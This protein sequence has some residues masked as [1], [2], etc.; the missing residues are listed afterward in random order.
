M[1]NAKLSNFSSLIIQSVISLLFLFAIFIIDFKL[2]K[3]LNQ[4]NENRIYSLM[5]MHELRQSSDDLTRMV[6]TY[7]VTKNTIYKQH[8]L[9]ILEIRNGTRKRP[10]DY[11][12]I[13]W[14]LVQTDNFRPKPFS[15]QSVALLE[16]MRDAK[17]THEEFVK[18]NEAKKKSDDLTQIELQAMRILESKQGDSRLN[19]QIALN[20]VH[21]NLYHEKKASI[22]K[23]IDECY[24]LIN[25]R[26]IKAVEDANTMALM[27]KILLNGIGL[28]IFYTFYRLYK[29][30]KATLGGSLDDVHEHI[31]KIGRGE[32]TPILIDQK[33]KNSILGWLS[34]TQERLQSLLRT[35]ERLKQLYSARSECNLAIVQSKNQTELFSRIC[36]HIVD[37]GG[38]KMAW[39]GIVNP[40][41]NQLDIAASFGD[42]LEYLDNVHIST[43]PSDPTST[44]PTGRAFKE[45]KP[46]WCQDF[47]HDPMTEKW[48]NMGEKFGWGASAAL[49][50]QCC[51][52]TIGVLTIYAYEINIFDPQIKKLLQAIA[53]DISHA[54]DNFQ[55]ETIRKE[56]ENKLI[57]T[58]QTAQN[59]LDIVDVIVLV[60][61]IHQKIKLL[62][63]KG[64]EILGYANDE[65]IEKDWVSTCIPK[66]DQP[67]IN[68]LITDLVT[69]QTPPPPYYEN[70]IVTKKGELRI[71]AW[72][73]QALYDENG[74]ITGFLCSG[75]DITEIRDTQNK[76][77]ESEDFYRTIVT[78]IDKAILILENK[79]IVDCNDVALSLFDTSKESLL[80]SD[81]DAFTW[82]FESPNHTFSYYLYHASHGEIARTECTFTTIHNT[83]KIL[84]LTLAQ[85]GDNINKIIILA[86][87]ITDKIAKDKLLTMHSRQAQMG[88]MISMIAHQ[89]RQPLAV[90]NAITTQHLMKECMKDEPDTL[91]LSNLDK[92]EKQSLYLSQTIND[93]RDFFRND[94]PKEKIDLSLFIEQALS[95]VDH[96]IKTNNI[97]IETLV[98]NYTEVY[99]YRNEV[100]QVI[101]TLLKN[102]VD[103]FLHNAIEK[104]L[105]IITIDHNDLYG[106]IKVYDNAGG[107]E[108]EYIKKIFD[109]YFTTKDHSLGTGLGLYMSKM[110]IEE[111][112]KGILEVESKNDETTFT[113]K[114]PLE[115][116]EVF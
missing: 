83:T 33:F 116:H 102:S 82:N 105:I 81:I 89:W 23:P 66:K 9:E 20:L 74:T 28:F 7:I 52:T 85:Y 63:R 11:N 39:I 70:E 62:N 34:E 87:D 111:H 19:Q 41:S 61:D 57:A 71:I 24:T 14:D 15:D 48:Q 98:N 112:C 114:L 101:V 35:N 4:S 96:T 99:S 31:I 109:P 84:D 103:A 29:E 100:L 72:R 18:L 40:S 55:N 59:Y 16:L 13:Y 107:I 43:E 104:P 51:D 86:R 17:F 46:Y 21:N 106:L 47:Q 27:M 68:A 110:V 6:R 37:F 54:L 45:N 22:M 25:A 113:I 97:R 94:K 95:L 53:Q 92:I 56:I 78:S 8:Y 90:I 77:I 67:M 65:I 76:L 44:G 36:H 79:H 64:C 60:L 30:L 91:L 38:L 10:V 50:I 73:N 2:E 3:N 32:S 26:T 88:E 75:D 80:G 69:S 115:N 12:N 108:E 5:L 42:G 58:T 49:P 1:Q 93:Y